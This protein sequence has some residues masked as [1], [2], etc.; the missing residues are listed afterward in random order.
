MPHGSP[1]NPAP[2]TP[3]GR[4]AKGSAQVHKPPNGSA[5]AFRGFRWMRDLWT[6]CRDLRALD[7]GGSMDLQGALGDV[8]ACPC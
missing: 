2:T 3:D 4:V 6:Q 7:V 1:E 5:R 8:D